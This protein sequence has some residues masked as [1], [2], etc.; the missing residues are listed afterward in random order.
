[1]PHRFLSKYVSTKTQNSAKKTVG[2]LTRTRDF[3]LHSIHRKP[4]HPRRWTNVSRDMAFSV[5]VYVSLK[6]ILCRNSDM[7]TYVQNRLN[8]LH[9]R[10][11]GNLVLHLYFGYM[12]SAT[13][14]VLKH[15][16][17]KLLCVKRTIPTDGWIFP[18][19]ETASILI[20]KR[21][22]K[23]AE[24]SHPVITGSKRSVGTYVTSVLTAPIAHASFP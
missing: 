20:R 24:E 4:R 9:G 2:V 16:P 11:Y 17:I 13:S 6:I 21:I 19:L 3:Y 10:E 14:Q 23:D 12:Y 18:S 1:M 7:K 8:I 22:S 15:V 5:Y